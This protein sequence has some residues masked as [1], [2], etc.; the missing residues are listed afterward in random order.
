[1]ERESLTWHKPLRRY[2]LDPNRWRSTKAGMWAWLLQR[3]SALAILLFLV[4]HIT[5]TYRPFIQFCLLVTVAFHAAL[6]LRVILLDFG[7]VDVK[8]QKT[9]LWALGGLVALLV[10][11]VW[12]GVY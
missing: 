4:L 2:E 12:L 1:M 10:L 8:Y 3:I 11:I 9:L 6:G 5:L 7:V